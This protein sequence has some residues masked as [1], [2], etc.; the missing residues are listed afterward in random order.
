MRRAR[1]ANAAAAAA[2]RGAVGTRR[3]A[4]RP[5]LAATGGRDRTVEGAPPAAHREP[6]EA[7]VSAGSARGTAE[8]GD[9]KGD[10]GKSGDHPLRRDGIGKDD[11][12]TEDLPGD[13]ARGGWDDRSYAA[14]ANRGAQRG[15]AHRP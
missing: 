15:N 8:G 13:R 3:Q 6:P 11:A 1:S 9:R 10:R 5:F 2:A 4:V 12:V 14:A 7:F